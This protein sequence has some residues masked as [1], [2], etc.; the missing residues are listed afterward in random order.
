MALVVKNLPMQETRDETSIPGWGRSPG[1]GNDNPLQ[2][3]CL[4]N[5]HGWSCL[6]AYSPW[7]CKRVRHD[8]MTKHQHV[9]SQ[10]I[11]YS[12]LCYTR[13]CCFYIYALISKFFIIFQYEV[14]SNFPYFSLTHRY[15]NYA[16]KVFLKAQFI[17]NISYKTIFV[18]DFNTYKNSSSI[19]GLKMVMY[20]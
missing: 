6:M 5:P 13:P 4:E 3:S 8:L 9:L 16:F 14:F 11:E 1:E 2:Y 10:D 19:F 7:G 18:I 12:P 20:W 15:V 17:R